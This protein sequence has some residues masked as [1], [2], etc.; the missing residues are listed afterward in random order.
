MMPVMS[1]EETG[2]IILDHLPCFD[3]HEPR[4]FPNAR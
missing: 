1:E 2:E 4:F 3:D